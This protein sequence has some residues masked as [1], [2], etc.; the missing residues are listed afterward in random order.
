MIS[1]NREGMLRV[2]VL[3][4]EAGL[5]TRSLEEIRSCLRLD[6]DDKGCRA[7]YAKVR[8]LAKAIE[9]AQNNAQSE[10]WS[11]CLPQARRI[12]ELEGGNPEYVLQGKVL[13]C[14]CGARVRVTPMM[15]VA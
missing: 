1:D 3:M 13:I 10:K 5:A 7:H 14:R 8:V 9:D 11:K 4:Y 12:L 15:L 2:S 6:P